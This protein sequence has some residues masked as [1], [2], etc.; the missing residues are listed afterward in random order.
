[1]RT[2]TTRRAGALAIAL[3]AASALVACSTA[4]AP[5]PDASTAPQ[6]DSVVV[7]DAWIKAA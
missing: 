5:G 1:M 3:A 2:I 7:A 6:A 4:D